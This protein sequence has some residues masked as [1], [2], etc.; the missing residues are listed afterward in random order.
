[1][2]GP[3]LIW[4]AGAIGGTI[5]AYLARA[6]ED[7]LFVDSAADHVAAMQSTGLTIEGPIE[8]FTL[9]VRAALPEQVEGRFSR[10]FLCVKAHHTEAASRALMP[11]LATSPPSRTASTNTSSARPSASSASSAPSSTS[12]PITWRRGASSMAGAAPV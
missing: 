10:I 4:G 11:H 1:V 6:G 2:T 7:V 8:Q 5:G 9:P 12:A 3:I